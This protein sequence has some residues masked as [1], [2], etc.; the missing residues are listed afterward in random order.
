MN[1]TNIDNR[2]LENKTKIVD[3]RVELQ[4]SQRDKKKITLL[5]FDIN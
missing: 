2:T 4:I 3:L 5:R 1:I